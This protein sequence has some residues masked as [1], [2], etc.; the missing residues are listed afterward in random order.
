M[1]NHVL[2]DS[3]CDN[4]RRRY[5]L[6]TKIGSGPARRVTGP[7]VVLA[8]PAYSGRGTGIHVALLSIDD[9]RPKHSST[10]SD[11]V[12]AFSKLPSN[13]LPREV[14]SEAEHASETCGRAGDFWS[15]WN[16]LPR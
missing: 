15:T 6:I 4:N 14:T 13:R 10:N 5:P 8:I 3:A 1:P 16:A 2:V 7:G 9:F 11:S 12:S